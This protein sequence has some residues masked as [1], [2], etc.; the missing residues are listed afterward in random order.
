MTKPLPKGIDCECGEHSAFSVWVYA[1]W[2]EDLIF[3]CD[4]CKKKY[5]LKRGVATPMRKGRSE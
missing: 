5:A 2:D 3:T 4:K 1:H